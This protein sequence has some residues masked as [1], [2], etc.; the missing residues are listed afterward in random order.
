[1]PSRRRSHPPAAVTPPPPAKLSTKQ[2]EELS[3]LKVVLLAA[4]H[5]VQ[6]AVR[7]E[8][9]RQAVDNALMQ[10]EQSVV[11]LRRIQEQLR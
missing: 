2:R 3:D 4:A 8:E 6:A 9:T 11:S 7:G 1:M 10:V 5:N